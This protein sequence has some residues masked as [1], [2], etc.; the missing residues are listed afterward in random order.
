MQVT[1][2]EFK[3]KCLKFL[4]TVNQT[5]EPMEISKHGQVVAVL[6]PP[7]REMPWKRLRNRGRV[8]AEPEETAVKASEIKA[9]R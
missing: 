7:R 6:N 4:D 2:T 3:A 1:A 9:L 8:L 5:G